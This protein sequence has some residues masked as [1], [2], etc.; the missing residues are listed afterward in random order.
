MAVVAQLFVVQRIFLKKYPKAVLSVAVVGCGEVGLKKDCFFFLR[1]AT[2]ATGE[3]QVP[4][5]LETYS[6]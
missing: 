4:R 5:V 1:G 3:R 6:G 2:N